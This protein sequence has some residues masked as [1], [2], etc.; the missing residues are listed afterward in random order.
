MP[1]PKP[2]PIP[3]PKPTATPKP[4]VA[5]L[6]GPS[7]SPT[8]TLY[9]KIH[10]IQ[11]I[12]AIEGFLEDGADWSYQIMVWNGEKWANIKYDV[13]G[14][15][16]DIVV[17]NIHSFKVGS[18]IVKFYII[19]LERD[20]GS[21]EV[22]DISSNSEPVK[23]DQRVPPPRG[24]IYEGIYNLKDNSLTGDKT[25]REEGYYKTSGDYD[26]STGRDENDANLW[27][28]IWDN[29]DPP[30][31]HIRVLNPEV[32]TY[33]KVNFDA[34]SSAA[35]RGSTLVKYEWDFES[36]GIVD[37][38]GEKASYVYTKTG[39]Y[40]V[41]LIVTDNFGEKA[42]DKQTVYVRNRPPIADFTFSP[43]KPDITTVIN[44]YDSSR[45]KD[46]TIV[47]WEWDFGD[48]TS[49]TE[50]NPTHQYS[51]KGKYKVTLRVTDN[52]GGQAIKSRT[53]IVY[54]LLPKASFTFSP[55]NPI[56]GEDVQFTDKS[57]DPEGKALI[58][59]W[60]FGDG[61]TSK[62][63]NPTHKYA[64]PGTYT[65]TLTV[66]DDEG[67]K[68]T[69]SKTISILSPT[70]QAPSMAQPPT[71]ATPKP[72]STPK[73]TATPTS[74]PTPTPTS[75]PITAFWTKIPTLYLYSI[76]GIIV[77]VVGVAILLKRG[78]KPSHP[79][80]EAR[81]KA[82]LELE[83]ERLTEMLS[84]FRKRYEEGEIDEE[85]YEKLK[86]KYQRKIEEIDEQ[87]T[88]LKER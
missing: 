35:S 10:R 63:R 70:T 86:S 28:A 24:A 37:A 88:K 5:P 15:H 84:E 77:V 8:A 75:S 81:E 31:A 26:G 44:F 54:N 48:G 16:N 87:L 19:L 49:S 27:F 3:T 39:R 30:K 22:A 57:T 12:D 62:L 72:A 82:L 64:N 18:T 58:Y 4:T 79:K 42:I 9:I 59:Y 73:P 6:Q 7:S 56:V 69:V 66:M 38:E 43:E 11:A 45:D 32:Y 80:P 34:S 65:V 74:T 23:Y 47:S 52:D 20:W 36:D 60:D 17:D 21:D 71:E 76:A 78:G 33:D 25:Y 51:D 68:D 67:A 1:T 29:Y 2:T 61:Y 13:K 85:S 40:T 46:G 41:T 83:K 55:T 14:D 50:K 53:V